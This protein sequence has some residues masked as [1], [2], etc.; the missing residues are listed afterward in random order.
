MVVVSHS[1]RHSEFRAHYC[2]SHVAVNWGWKGVA[3]VFAAW[4]IAPGIAGAFS[5]IIYLIIKYGILERENSTRLALYAG[6]GVSP[7][8]HCNTCL[9]SCFDQPVWFFVTSAI[10]TMSVVWKGAP[11]LKLDKLSTGTTISQFTSFC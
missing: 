10:L 3:Q 9:T 11:N 8:S 6:V 5:A 1:P 4:G 2:L 7:P